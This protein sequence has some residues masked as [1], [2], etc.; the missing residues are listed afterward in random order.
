MANNMIPTILKE[1]YYANQLLNVDDFNRERDFHIASR[2]LLSSFFIQSGILQ[3]LDVSQGS[4][5][6][7]LISPG[8]AIDERGSLILLT[9]RAQLAD[10]TIVA[11]SGSVAIDLSAD[12]YANK[13]W[14]LVIQAHDTQVADNALQCCPILTLLEPSSASPDSTQIPLSKITVT[15][16]GTTPEDITITI[17]LDSS[18]RQLSKL[19]AIR[20]PELLASQIPDLDASKVVSGVLD[21][22]HIPDLDASKIAS[23]LLDAALIP[24][25]DA[26]K[27]GFGV[28]DAAHI[29]ALD[30]S[31]I[32]SGTLDVGRLPRIPA[33]HITGL[34]TSELITYW[35]SN[36]AIYSSGGVLAASSLAVSKPSC[37]IGLLKIESDQGNTY[38]SLGMGFPSTVIRFDSDQMSR[39]TMSFHVYSDRTQYNLSQEGG[40]EG[41]TATSVQFVGL[42]TSYC[43][44]LLVPENELPAENQGKIWSLVTFGTQKVSADSMSSNSISDIIRNIRDA[45]SP[46]SYIAYAVPSSISELKA[47]L[48]QQLKS[49]GLSAQQAAPILAAHAPQQTVGNTAEFLKTLTE[50][51]PETMSEPYQAAWALSAA[52][53]PAA[54]AIS[55]I[56]VFYHHLISVS[57]FLQLILG[58]YPPPVVAAQISAQQLLGASAADAALPIKQSSPQFDS[59]PTQLGIVLRIHF[60]ATS[61]TPP[62]MAHALREADYS[63]DDVIS[64][65]VFLFP[66]VP[67]EDLLNVVNSEFES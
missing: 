64:A 14:L 35:A 3:G 38:I 40:A 7:V 8:A 39:S 30:A 31:L 36:T 34:P 63:K 43:F 23:G 54:E 13:T 33:S 18:V 56:G 9:D 1:R 50:V 32:A 48:A 41:E 20:L 65:L 58:A 49:D 67:Q 2:E 16:T 19:Q 6:N 28:L 26:S 12:V 51:F 42:D 5:N 29:P 61:S 55:A 52:S 57:D 10:N 15:S 4:Q 17:S 62:L 25:L 44:S 53:I 11:Q 46:F 24:A 22:A 45:I 21:A 60:D 47:S 37:V 59:L 66:T 27:I